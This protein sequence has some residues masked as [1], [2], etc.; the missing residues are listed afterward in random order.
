MTS[1]I[2]QRRASIASLEIFAQ[3]SEQELDAL[4]AVGRIEKLPARHELF[5]KGDEA[6]TFFLILSGRLKVTSTSPEGEDVVF[7]IMERGESIGEVALFASSPRTGTVTTLDPSELFVIQKQDFV[8]FLRT[9]PDATLSVL[10]TLA[11]RLLRL[12]ERVEDSRFL[13]L[14][15]RLAK[16][17]LSLER[18]FSRPVAE[19][20]MIELKLSQTDLAEMAGAS[21]E[22]VNKQMRDWKER[23][24][25]HHDHGDVTILDKERLEKETIL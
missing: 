20:V 7:S 17:L 8:R 12:S 5:H 22:A 4:I 25:A 10:E 19:G 2:E 13:N 23:G 3:L 21:R 16:L 14:P 6:H 11:G 15:G 1:L 24:I 9:H 18:R